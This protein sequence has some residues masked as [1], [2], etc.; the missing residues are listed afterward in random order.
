MPRINSSDLKEVLR[1]ARLENFKNKKIEKE[2]VRKESEAS[3]RYATIWEAL[4]R[5]ALDGESLVRLDNLTIDEVKYFAN[6]GLNI[7]VQF[8]RERPYADIDLQI[9]K[10]NQE[11]K[12]ITERIK[13][14]KNKI[15][16]YLDCED[17]FAKHLSA[18][19]EWLWKNKTL[20]FQCDLEGWF[21]AELDTVE[22]YSKEELNDF[23]KDV[24]QR[25][26]SAHDVD[27]RKHLKSLKEIVLKVVSACK[28]D[29]IDLDEIQDEIGA[30][31]LVLDE[32]MEDVLKLKSEEDYSRGQDV[33]TTHRID[34]SCL[35]GDVPQKT[36][37]FSC[38][39][40]EWFSSSNGQRTMA[41]FE[42]AVLDLAKAGKRSMAMKCSPHLTDDS[43]VEIV[44]SVGGFRG[45][46]LSYFDFEMAMNLLEYKLETKPAGKSG[47]VKGVNLIIKW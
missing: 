43:E 23:L 47:V 16:E 42:K 9:T 25:I 36:D 8:I 7:Q 35:V 6:E 30:T 5:A 3:R 10:K 1:K 32:L 44:S 20:A 12:K 21:G 24:N 22:I 37:D 33:D 40:L 38:A 18:V 46:F 15:E 28:G 13:Y 14:L 27:R 45:L 26:S 29:D 11:I 41:N 19:E 31:E 39:G 17:F 4:Y 34:W 2:R